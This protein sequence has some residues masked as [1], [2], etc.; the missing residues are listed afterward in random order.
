ME[1]LD[2]LDP[3]QARPKIRKTFAIPRAN[4]RICQSLI[5]LHSGVKEKRPIRLRESALM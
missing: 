1:I 5:N 3:P 2:C 4:V